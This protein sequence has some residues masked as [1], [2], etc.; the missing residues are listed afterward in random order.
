MMEGIFR[1]AR[2]KYSGLSHNG[3]IIPHTRFG[4]R[5]YRED[6]ERT[7]PIGIR[8]ADFREGRVLYFVSEDEYRATVKGELVAKEPFFPDKKLIVP[9][10]VMLPYYFHKD[11]THTGL[12]RMGERETILTEEDAPNRIGIYRVL[13]ENEL[14]AAKTSVRADLIKRGLKGQEFVIKG[15]SFVAEEP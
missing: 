3:G 2:D 12:V 1:R 5:Y 15:Y 6:P 4:Y 9:T 13:D 14:R 8:E 10:K 7:R 11:E